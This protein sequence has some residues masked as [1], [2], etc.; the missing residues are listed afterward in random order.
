[1]SADALALAV[2]LAATAASGLR[3]L[4]VAQ[5]EHYLPGSVS[6]F[7]WRWWSLGP[8][9]VLFVAWGLGAGLATTGRPLPALFGAAA[10]GIGPF[11]LS[12]RGRTSPLAW[13]RRLRTLAAA[14]AALQLVLV[15]LGALAGSGVA[16]V[17]A[18]LGA[19]LVP[20]LVDAA[21]A[22]TEPV[23]RRLGEPWVDKAKARLA[24]VRP[25]VVAITGSYGKTSTKGYVAQLL[26][27]TGRW[28]PPL[29]ASTTGPAWPGP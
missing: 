27:P 12:I 29:A 4:R 10:A 20:V 24:Q 11:G 23:E 19:G 3:W 25:T 2:A 13:T 18:A 1:V 26:A 9:L 14:W 17:A 5:R 16:V 28:C 6:R 15:G 21:L 22:A 8:N 7:A